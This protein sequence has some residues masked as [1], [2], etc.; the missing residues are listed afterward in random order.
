M[1]RT[2]AR[3]R[4]RAVAVLLPVLALS[5]CGGSDLEGGGIPVDG[6]A[7]RGILRVVDVQRQPYP[8]VLLGL[9]EA[10]VEDTGDY[11]VV[12]L[13]L[14]NRSSSF[15]E[16]FFFDQ[17]A[18]GW[19]DRY[20]TSQYVDAVS[21]EVPQDDTAQFELT[22]PLS[23]TGAI[24]SIESPEDVRVLY[25]EETGGYSGGFPPSGDL[26]TAEDLAEV[27]VALSELWDGS[28]DG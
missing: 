22:F 19:G 28:F 6:D 18:V 15:P 26:A 17:L 4:T 20:V 2:N 25:N 1:S 21:I 23:S 11:L 3:R 27:D 24:E 7:E 16:T 8:G 10:Q 13:E 9:E 5:G 12:S 14:E